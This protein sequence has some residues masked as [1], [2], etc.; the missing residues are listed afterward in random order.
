MNNRRLLS[1]ARSFRQLR[2]FHHVINSDRVFGT[3]NRGTTYVVPTRF[4]GNAISLAHPL[5]VGL[6]GLSYA[7]ERVIEVRG[8]V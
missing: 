8:M 3:H 7:E 2:R 6:L 4:R 1:S 5:N